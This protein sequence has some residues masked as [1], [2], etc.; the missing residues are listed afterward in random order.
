MGVRSSLL[1][2]KLARQACI[3]QKC[4]SARPR[5]TSERFL[6]KYVGATL[7]TTHPLGPLQDPR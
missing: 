5:H 6:F 2:Q 3:S 4:S 1:N 7:S